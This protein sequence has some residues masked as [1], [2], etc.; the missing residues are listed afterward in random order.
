MK[1]LK[2]L[3]I[4]FLLVLATSC[5]KKDDDGG[6][7]SPG[8]AEF[9]ATINGGGF[10]NYSSNLGSYSTDTSSGTGLTIAVTDANLNV[11]RFFLNNSG[12]FDSGVIKEIGN[13][14]Q[15]SALF[16][17]QA[18]NITYNGSDGSISITEN[19]TNPE[20]DDSSRIISGTFNITTS[21]NL[22]TTIV[23]LSGSFK[24]FQYTSF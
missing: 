10:N 23:T 14:S 3:S 1:N 7:G 11:I 17:D 6:G 21:D 8:E 5:S 24:D 22:G 15:S 2:T 20:G 16:R 13:G 9:N 12:G 19:R 4:L 18:E